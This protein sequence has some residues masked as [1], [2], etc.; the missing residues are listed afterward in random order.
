MF[1]F[2]GWTTKGVGRVNPP[3]HFFLQSGCYSPKI[4]KKKKKMP[5]S[6]IGYYTTKKKEEKK[7]AWTTKPLVV[8]PLKKP[9][10]YVCLPLLEGRQHHRICAIPPLLKKTYFLMEEAIE[11]ETRFHHSSSMHMLPSHRRRYLN[12]VNTFNTRI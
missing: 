3:H 4:G 9:L 1:F 12:T 8:R 10:F 2:S 6:V 7:V 11:R 5:K